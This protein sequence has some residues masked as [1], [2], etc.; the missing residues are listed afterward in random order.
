MLVLTRKINESIVIGEDANL[1][2]K[3]LGING[4]QVR[5]GIEAPKNV[6]V[7][8]E[9]IYQRIQQQHTDAAEEG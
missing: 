3:V 4:N 9:E 6:P 7:H 8:R 2:L 5:L 1:T